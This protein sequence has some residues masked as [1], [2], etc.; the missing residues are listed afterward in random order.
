MMKLRVFGAALLLAAA[1]APVRAQADDLASKI[2]NDPGNPQVNGAKASLRDD[3][4][5]QGGRALRI[6]VP[7]KGANPWDSTAES[8]LTMPVKAGDQLELIFWARLEKGDGGAASSSLAFA[9]I[10]INA[11]PYTSVVQQQPV[12][13]GP[14]WKMVEIK[15]KADR[16][17]PAGGLKVSIHLANA[18]QTIDLGPIV[19]LNLGPG[20]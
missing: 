20:A 14:E 3:P 15:G 6:Q 12:D 11:A 2:V 8:T 4:K 16:N 19:V 10:Q 17:Y 5:V 7:K 18:K 13:V 9:G 1:A